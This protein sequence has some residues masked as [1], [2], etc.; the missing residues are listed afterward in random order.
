M[1]QQGKNNLEKLNEASGKNKKGTSKQIILAND[2][3]KNK[4][5]PRKMK[6]NVKFAT[7]NVQGINMLG[8]RQ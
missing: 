8:K 5:K 7:L 3:E 1:E 6:N 2:M 4:V